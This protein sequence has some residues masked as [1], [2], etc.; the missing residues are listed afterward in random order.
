[1]TAASLRKH[2]LGVRGSYWFI[3]TILTLFAFAL[4]L[5][6][7]YLDRVWGSEWL[8]NL[9]WYEATRPEAAR[10][11]LN[12]VATGLLSVSSTL[13]AITIAAVAFASGNYGP[14]LLANFMND[15][16]N[17]VS[18]GVFVATFV[19]NLM[20]LRVVRDDSGQGGGAGGPEAVTAFVPQLSMLVSTVSVAISVGTL[21][22]FLHHT[23]SSIRI[24]TVLAGIG[25]HL[26]RSIEER[27]P[28]DAGPQEAREPERGE[29]VPADKIGYVEIIAFSELDSIARETGG[30]ISLNA[31]TGDFV[32]PHRP[33]AELSGATLD[34]ELKNRI[35]A[36][37]SLGASR[38][39]EQDIEFLIDELVEIGLRA[40]SPG[41]NDPFTA[42]TSIHW[43]GAAMARLAERDLG[44]GPEH[45]CYDRE[46]VQVVA[47][48]FAHFLKRSFGSIRP[49]VA[50][51]PIAAKMFL[52]ALWGVAIGA[53]SR[54]R[55]DAIRAEAQRLLRQSETA[56]EGPA[57]E[58]VRERVAELE[59]KMAGLEQ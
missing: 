58:E 53:T 23:P 10:A 7:I 2:W 6:T 59:R 47:D 57:L 34:E 24:N 32:H 33:L 1:M 51:S 11:Q 54:E 12:V 35:R 22:Y 4:A 56:L 41:I 43:M 49:S 14:R 5:L 19:Y 29:P 28:K 36:C 20:L 40:L 18:L 8:G 31:R 48:D 21:V 26:V 15:R 13:F 3:P 55:R 17:Q 50:G 16:G 25:R 37:F 42:V 9:S 46:R 44:F 39:P 45:E 52:D 38:T 30:T 27:F